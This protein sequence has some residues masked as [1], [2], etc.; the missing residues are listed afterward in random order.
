MEDN[1]S[2]PRAPRHFRGN[3][4]LGL[5]KSFP[6]SQFPSE[7]RQRTLWTREEIECGRDFSETH[8]TTN[9]EELVWLA[10]HHEDVISRGM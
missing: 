4:Q 7:T 5:S 6:S 3:T 8:S 10:F 1:S 2:L 9:T